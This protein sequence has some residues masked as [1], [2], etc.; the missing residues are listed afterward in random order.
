MR[1][2]SLLFVPGDRPERLIK[3]VASGADAVIIDLEDSVALPNKSKAREEV[4]SFISGAKSEPKLFIRVNN[5]TSSYFLEDLDALS[6]AHPFAIVLPRCE[7]ARDIELAA[8]HLSRVGCLETKILPISTETPQ[9]VLNLGNYGTVAKYLCGLTWGTE[10]LPSSIGALNAWEADGRLT[11]PYEVVRTFA[12][13]G[14]HAAGVAAIDTAFHDY[15][16]LDGLR[17]F[18]SRGRRDGFQGMLAVHPSQIPIINE[19]YTPNHSEIIWAQQVIDAFNRNPDAPMINVDGKSVD[20][21]RLT[22]AQK[23]MTNAA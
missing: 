5:L 22:M 7:G 15:K 21:P 14:A 16:D 17:S 6:K 2:R 20:R 11:P 4:A 10:D 12:L 9:G 1:L 18:A 23:I 8:A 13:F 3:A 19:A